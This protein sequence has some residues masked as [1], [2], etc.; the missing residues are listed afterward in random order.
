MIVYRRDF[1]IGWRH[2]EVKHMVKYEFLTSIQTFCF[3]EQNR[4]WFIE[5]EK[6]IKSNERGGRANF[7]KFRLH[8]GRQVSEHGTPISDESCVLDIWG[9]TRLPRKINSITNVKTLYILFYWIRLKSQSVN[10]TNCTHQ[11]TKI[12]QTVPT[13]NPAFDLTFTFPCPPT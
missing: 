7:L 3:T 4:K 2:F 12:Y 5:F 9:K 10:D 1:V 11:D 8:H 6:L 13:L